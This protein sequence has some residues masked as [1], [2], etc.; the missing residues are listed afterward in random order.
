MLHIWTS[1]AQLPPTIDIC[2][3]LCCSFAKLSSGWLVWSSQT[4]LALIKVITYP[5]PPIPTLTQ[6]SRDT[7]EISIMFFLLQIYFL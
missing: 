6:E 4:D 3:F 1:S 5:P 7:V 2:L